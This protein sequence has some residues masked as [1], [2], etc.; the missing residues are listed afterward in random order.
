MSASTTAERL[1]CALATLTARAS[2]TAERVT[3]SALCEVANV[4]RNSVYRYHPEVL[5]AL[6]AHQTQVDRAV[7]RRLRSTVSPDQAEL[8]RLRNQ[9]TKLVALVDHFYAAYR[10]AQTLLARRERELAELRRQIDSRPAKLA[11]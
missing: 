7:A 5:Q 4:S 11:R 10:E 3:L 6:R 9:A 8:K 2:G 1:R